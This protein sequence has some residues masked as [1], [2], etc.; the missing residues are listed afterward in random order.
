[1]RRQSVLTLFLILAVLVL[2]APSSA[3]AV[4]LVRVA[5]GFKLLTHTTSSPL[6][7]AVYVVEQKGRIWRVGGGGRSL[8]LDI[9]GLVGFSWSGGLF[10]VAF[11]SDY[12]QSRYL[13]V[14]YTDN[15]GDVRVARFTANAAFTRAIKSTRRMLIDVAHSLRLNHYGGQVVFGPNGR[16]YLSVGDGGG[17]CDPNENA[18]DL[19]SRKGKLLSID[20]DAPSAG[21]RIDGYGLRNL[22]RFAF[23]RSTGRFYGADVG[24]DTWEEINSVPSSRLGGRAENYLWDRYEGFARG[25]CPSGGLRGSGRRLFP[26]YVYRHS[27]G[28][29]AIT[30]GHVYRGRQLPARVRGWYFFADFCSGRIWRLKLNND[31]RLVRDARL[32]TNTG[33]KITSFGERRDGELLVVHRRGTIY[34]ISG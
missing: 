29:C 26:K 2:T 7:N 28:N 21:W 17:A 11:P 19:P 12:A 6:D 3:A 25:G 8:F 33:L 34:K 15:S 5:G 4:R 32:V 1:M 31:G 14:N 18:Q 20:T 10:S 24:Q 16:L 30:G 27:R 9:R 22:W 13:Y 23:D